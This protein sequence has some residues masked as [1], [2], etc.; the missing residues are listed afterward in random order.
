MMMPKYRANA[1]FDVND[2][3]LTALIVVEMSV[4]LLALIPI[5]LG[6]Y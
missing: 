5:N 1:K 2:I 6:H 4:L 3:N